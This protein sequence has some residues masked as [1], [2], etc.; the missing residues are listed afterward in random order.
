MVLKLFSNVLRILHGGSASESPAAASE[1]DFTTSNRDRDKEEL[2][3]KIAEQ[4][5]QIRKLADVASKYKML[6][7][8]NNMLVSSQKPG[9]LKD[10]TEEVQK[11]LGELLKKDE[12]IKNISREAKSAI[13]IL[14][15]KHQ[16]EI[17]GLMK[18][19]DNRAGNCNPASLVQLTSCPSPHIQCMTTPYRFL[20]FAHI[21][22]FKLFGEGTK[23][24]ALQLTLYRTD[25]LRMWPH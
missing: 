20:G 5:E 13:D 22:T 23:I 25:Q 2:E 21:C 1:M 14:K 10:L 24:L 6:Q 18:Q 9:S 17:E 15:A 19:R 12:Q 11:L 4:A 8:E 3:R 7:R 16:T